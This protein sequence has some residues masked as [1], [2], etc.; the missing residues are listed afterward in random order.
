[1]LGF[2]IITRY[3]QGSVFRWGRAPPDVR[4]PV[5]TQVRPFT[6]R[7][8]KVNMQITV[9]APADPDDDD[10]HLLSAAS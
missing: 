6:D 8:A 10:H 1:M 9:A 4:K 5:L 7:F 2:K 3:E